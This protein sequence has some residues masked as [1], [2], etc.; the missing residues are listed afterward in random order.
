MT[1][2][3]RDNAIDRTRLLLSVQ[4]ALV[5]AIGV[6]IL[7]ICVKTNATNVELIVF[8]DDNLS[9]DQLEAL[10]IAT[11][12]IVADFG[13]DIQVSFRAIENAVQ[14]FACGGIWVFLRLGY[15]VQ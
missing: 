8:S 3:K 14:P 6:N 11:T 13:P 12:E 1:K 4:Q 7:A 15:L 2:L 9:L 5:G 10:D